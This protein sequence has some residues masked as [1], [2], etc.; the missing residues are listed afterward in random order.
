[1]S[2]VTKTGARFTVR[3]ESVLNTLKHVSSQFNVCIS[4]VFTSLLNQHYVNLCEMRILVLKLCSLSVQL[5]VLT[6]KVIFF[7]LSFVLR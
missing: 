6:M 2:S 4:L 7:Y 1:M 5:A 3:S